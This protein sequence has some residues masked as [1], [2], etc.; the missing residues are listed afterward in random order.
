[1]TTTKS[2]HFSSNRLL[3]Y[4][5]RRLSNS[6]PRNPCSSFCFS[7]NSDNCC[8]ARMADSRSALASSNSSFNLIV[9]SSIIIDSFSS[10]SNI[11]TRTLRAGSSI[12]D[13]QTV[14]RISPWAIVNRALNCIFSSSNSSYVFFR[15]GSFE[16]GCL[17]AGK[18]SSN[19]RLILPSSSPPLV[20]LRVLRSELLAPKC[21][22]KDMVFCS[23]LLSSSSDCRGGDGGGI[24]SSGIVASAADDSARLPLPIISKASLTIFDSANGDPIGLVAIMLTSWDGIALN[25]CDLCCSELIMAILR[26][27]SSGVTSSVNR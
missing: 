23:F 3:K 6:S 22:P 27:N 21:C 10:S 5:R 13:W 17:S 4:Q 20:P 2:T 25:N 1:M 12:A 7:I 24:S 19:M 11:M 15:P 8:A 18:T 26:P 14:A 9:S 16:A